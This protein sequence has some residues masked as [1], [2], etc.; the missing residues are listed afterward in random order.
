MFPIINIGPLAIQ[1]SGLIII[2]G[3]W[4]S[5]NIVEKY[6]LLFVHPDRNFSKVL[7]WSLI[8]ILI[9]ARLSYIIQFPND[10]FGSPISIISFNMALFDFAS[11]IV[12][13]AILFVVLNYRNKINF[14]ASLNTIT[15]GLSLFL[16]FYSL[17]LLA[18]GDYFG[19]PTSLPWGIELW[20][21]IRHPLQIYF[22][23]GASLIFSFVI[24]QIWLKKINNLFLK[25]LICLSTL[26][27][28]L[29]YF[30]GD[31]LNQIANVNVYQII[32]FL[33]L[34]FSLFKLNFPPLQL[35][36]TKDENDSLN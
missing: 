16:I 26:I 15:P 21:V 35:V 28:F 4:F 23:A 17:S 1:S 7:S 19:L 14:T 6:S 24:R 11:G 20:G 22:M 13:A 12:M 9:F 33:I 36:L 5:L 32:S 25:F 27:I 10:F 18:V 34:T 30:R 2:I 3:I 8:S 31:G 29:E